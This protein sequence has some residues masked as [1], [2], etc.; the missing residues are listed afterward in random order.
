MRSFSPWILEAWATWETLRKLDFKS[1]DIFWVFERVE[2]VIPRPGMALNIVLKTQDKVM[3][4]TCSH[5]LS[6]GEARRLQKHT[7]KFQG[8]LADGKFDETEMNEVLHASFIWKNKADLLFALG[9]KGFEFPFKLNQM[10]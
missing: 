9:A 5:R 1:D 8:L 2:N 7:A 4:I 3:T 10:N 6:E